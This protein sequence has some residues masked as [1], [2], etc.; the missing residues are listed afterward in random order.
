MRRFLTLCL[1]L[2]LL[3][4]CS[5]PPA[6]D[7]AAVERTIFA[8]DTVMNVRVYGDEA[9]LGAAEARVKELE[10]LLSVTD[11]NSEIYA[12]NRD[13]SAALSGDTAA[14]LTN[15]LEL[16]ARTGGALDITIYPV[17][18]LW[19]FTTGEYAV[20]DSG[21]VEELLVR[22]DYTRVSLDEH[23]GTAS[24][25]DGV[26]L[27]LGS[28]AKGYTGDVLSGLLKTYKVKSA[29]L[30]LGGNIHAVGAKPDGTPG[31]SA[32]GT[33]METASWAWWKPLTA[34]WSPPGATSGTLSRTACAIGTFWTR[35][36][37]P[38][39][40]RACN[41]SPLLARAA[42]CATRCPPP[43]SSWAWTGRWSIGGN[44]GISRRCSSATTAPLPSPPGWKTILRW[45]R[46]TAP[47]PSPG[48][49]A[50][51]S[52]LNRKPSPSG[53]GLHIPCGRAVLPRKISE[54]PG[55]FHI[56]T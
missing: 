3:S 10:A 9:L 42:L 6:G 7:A 17:V 33:R 16:C 8:M 53:G 24:L 31:A 40:G 52:Y 12:L 25:S 29:L 11:E 4:G 18:R 55:K 39:P 32:S 37:G 1:A 2:A 49:E 20:P 30:D 54:Y 5:T 43:C 21:S 41:R 51:V 34:P 47:S 28:V 48:P 45:S 22:V 19:G 44:T 23:A 36:P 15:A 35:P 46:R 50:A 56:S 26:K 27:D 38:P 14:L 13:G